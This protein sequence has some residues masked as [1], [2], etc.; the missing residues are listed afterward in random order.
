MRVEV[1]KGFLL[2]HL[3]ITCGA[4]DYYVEVS[5]GPSYIRQR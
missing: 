1:D 4:V 2:L 3:N 5:V